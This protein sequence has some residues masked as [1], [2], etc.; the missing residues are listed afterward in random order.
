MFTVF[1][2]IL[3]PYINII[4]G[5]LLFLELFF[6]ILSKFDSEVR[7]FIHN[8]TLNDSYFIETMIISH[9]LLS[10]YIN[11]LIC[12]K[13]NKSKKHCKLIQQHG[14]IIPMLIYIDTIDDL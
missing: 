14:I 7:C 1:S 8:F 2:T 13:Q 10:F 6:L 12:K 5:L 9:N 11:M 3:T 4:R